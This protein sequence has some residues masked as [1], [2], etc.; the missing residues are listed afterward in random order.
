M[1]LVKVKEVILISEKTCLAV[2]APLDDMER[3]TRVNKSWSS[4]H[5]ILLVMGP[6]PY[7]FNNSLFHIYL[8]NESMLYINPS[9][10]SS[11]EVSNQ[12]FVRWW[13]LERVFFDYVE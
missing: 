4:W 8:I 9:R 3:N 11:S 13:V 12:F 5:A 6:E 10:V 1:Q 7:H 2:V